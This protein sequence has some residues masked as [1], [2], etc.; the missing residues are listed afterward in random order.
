M[1]DWIYSNREA[2]SSTYVSIGHSYAESKKLQDEHNHFTMGSNNVFSNI[3][4]IL[5]DAAKLI[6]NS[7]YAAQHVRGVA[8]RLDQTWKDFAGCLD[9]RTTVL[10][11]SVLFHQKAEQVMFHQFFINFSSIFHQF[12]MIYYT[13]I[14]YDDSWLFLIIYCTTL[15]LLSFFLCFAIYCSQLIKPFDIFAQPKIAIFALIFH[16]LKCT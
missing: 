9:E 14:T 7:H 11:L 8:A 2:F 4:R 16:L 3:N 12:F 15:K 1:F 10:A 13:E 5:A 6:E